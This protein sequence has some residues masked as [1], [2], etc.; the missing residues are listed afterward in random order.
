VE[1]PK[2]T[3]ERKFTYKGELMADSWVDASLTDAE[4]CSTCAA[5]ASSA[6][7]QSKSRTKFM[8]V[9]RFLVLDGEITV[10]ESSQI[11]QRFDQNQTKA[12]QEIIGTTIPSELGDSLT[13]FMDHGWLGFWSSSV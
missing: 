6:K 3:Y 11:E 10:P 5:M 7:W 9:L 8:K 13:E 2:A 12:I 1:L 4:H